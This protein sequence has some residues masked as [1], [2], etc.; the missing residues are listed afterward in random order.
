[1]LTGLERL[2]HDPIAALQRRQYAAV[3][4]ISNR[5]RVDEEDLRI[6][7]ID[8]DEMRRE[9]RDGPAVDLQED[10]LDAVDEILVDDLASAANLSARVEEGPDI[11]RDGQ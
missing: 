8:P 11:R 7:A 5:T 9:V 1:M 10:V 6:V 4:V 3:A 2:E